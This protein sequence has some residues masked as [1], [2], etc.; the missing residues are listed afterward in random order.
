M[1]N[2]QAVYKTDQLYKAEIVK[3]F[4]QNS[5]L[6]PIIVDKKDSAYLIGY[7][8]I[9]VVNDDVLR[10]IKLIEDDVKFE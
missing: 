2:W 4:L 6:H 5:S 9:R 1:S 8:E 7:Y 3:D 10:A